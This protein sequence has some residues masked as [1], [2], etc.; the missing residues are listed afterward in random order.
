MIKL[1]NKRFT[2]IPNDFCITFGRDSTCEKCA[3]D[4]EI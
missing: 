1:A 2:S 3:E 4:E